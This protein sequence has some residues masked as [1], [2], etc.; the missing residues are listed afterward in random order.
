MVTQNVKL[1]GRK[2]G[3]RKMRRKGCLG[4]KKRTKRTKMVENGE[5]GDDDGG[6]DDDELWG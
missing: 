4:G 3:Q 1:I 5:G 2:E 6:D